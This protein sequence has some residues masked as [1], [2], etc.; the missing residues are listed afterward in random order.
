ML[1]PKHVENVRMIAAKNVQ[2]FADYVQ[3]LAVKLAVAKKIRSYVK[4]HI[5]KNERELIRS[6]S[7]N[8]GTIE[9]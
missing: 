3:M 2:K 1:V 4:K 8:A 6:L 7:F 5:I 9:Q